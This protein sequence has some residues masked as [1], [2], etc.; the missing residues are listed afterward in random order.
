[1]KSQ[2]HQEK[3]KES[4]DKRTAERNFTAGDL[5]LKWDA[6][7]EAKRKH[8]KFDNIWLGPFKVVV[9]QDNNTYELDQVDGELFVTLANG[10]FLKHL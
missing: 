10:K 7:R 5:V 2:A 6:K 8:E 4:F 1:M 3:M 9:A